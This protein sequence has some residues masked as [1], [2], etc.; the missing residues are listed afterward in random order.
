MRIIM[1]ASGN[2]VCSCDHRR[3][4]APAGQRVAASPMPTPTSSTQRPTSLDA[5]DGY[6]LALAARAPR[7]AAEERQR[8]SASPALKAYPQPKVNN[9]NPR[10]MDEI[11]GYRI[12][13]AERARREG[14]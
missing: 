11:D 2:V 5:L 3:H 14:R 6:A 8:T 13:L 12:A 7:E 4:A 9:L 10:N 1:R